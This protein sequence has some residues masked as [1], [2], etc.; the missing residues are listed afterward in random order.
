MEAQQPPCDTVGRCCAAM[1][2]LLVALSSPPLPGHATAAQASL[3]AALCHDLEPRLH[4]ALDAIRRVDALEGDLAATAQRA[5]QSPPRGR[6][7][8]SPAAALAAAQ[9]DEISAVLNATVARHLSPQCRMPPRA[10][11]QQSRSLP[12]PESPPQLPNGTPGPEPGAVAAEFFAHRH[13]RSPHAARQR[14]PLSPRNGWPDGAASPPLHTEGFCAAVSG[15]PRAP[16]RCLPTQ[17]RGNRGDYRTTPQ[18]VPQATRTGL[19]VTLPKS[20]CREGRSASPPSG[21]GRR[22]SQSLPRTELDEQGPRGRTLSACRSPSPRAV[23]RP[24]APA[25]VGSRDQEFIL[26]LLRSLELDHHAAAFARM[27]LLSFYGLSAADLAALGLPPAAVSALHAAVSHI[28]RIADAQHRNVELE[29]MAAQPRGQ[30][31][32][33]LVPGHA[34]PTGGSAALCTS[35][36]RVP[37]GASRRS[38]SPPSP[39]SSPPTAAAPPTPPL[40]APSSAP[41][42]ATPLR[43]H[44]GNVHAVRSSRALAAAS[45]LPESTHPSTAT[46]VSAV[47]AEQP[48]PLHVPSRRALAAEVPLP[49]WGSSAGGSSVCSSAV[50]LVA[51]EA[52]RRGPSVRAQAAAAAL[53]ATPA[54]SSAP[55]RS[56]DGA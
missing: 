6:G 9:A 56:P 48:R 46:R 35:P 44:T 53:P 22:R 10:P 50:D 41:P 38:P 55:A 4:R 27:D 8:P 19:S 2:A 20:L 13:R 34:H 40:T 18:A 3:R 5:S 31:P 39:P 24:G 30:S 42:P 15:K 33:R 12:R 14:G 51:L 36:P 7:G 16:K 45:P 43:Q 17:P 1:R 32:R 54:S 26:S 47:S 52:M 25:A 21:S 29:I 37:P 28:R 23:Q 49:P 11:R